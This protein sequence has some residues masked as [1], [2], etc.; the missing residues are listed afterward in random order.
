MGSPPMVTHTNSKARLLGVAASTLA[1]ATGATALPTGPAHAADP[2]TAA[3][4][5][6][7]AY[8]YLSE[9]RNMGLRGKGVTI[10][11]IDGEVDTTAPELAKTNITDKTPC[12]ITSST[13][14]KTHGTAMASIIASDAYGVAPDATIL[15]YRMSF[16]AQGDTSGDDC[17]DAF[18]VRKDTY[19]SLMNHAMN[20]GATVINMSVSSDEQQDFLKWAVARAISQGVIVVGAAGNSG[21]NS[22]ALALSWW[23]SVVGVGAIDTQGKVVDSSS[24]GEGLVSAAVG[25]ATVRDYSTGANTVVTG[26]SV[27]TA[28]VSGFVALARQQWPQATSNQ[29]LQLLVH[30]G[31]NPNH[32]WNDRTGYGP[33]DP[34]AMVNTDPSQYPDENPLMTKRPDVEPTPEQVQQYVDGVVSPYDI[35][36]DN[37]YTY[38]GLDERVVDDNR[39][40]YPTH[41]GTSP[42][43]HGKKA[44][45]AQ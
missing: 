37:S 28:L 10:A 20:D 13:Q 32:T 33:A 7:F 36:Y 16:T 34:G 11:L 5:S 30:T 3:D 4:Q 25:T 45:G 18:G 31:T 19:A 8:Y 12:T 2:I 41:L 38:R 26:T 39:N 17:D 23:S 40:H 29:L 14:S 43:Y 15:S 22:D 35:A 27:S 42:R 1:L 24:S 9:A 44:N 21:R 6:Y